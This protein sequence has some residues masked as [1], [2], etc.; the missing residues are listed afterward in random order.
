MPW[1]GSTL[2]AGNLLARLELLL[3]G[4]D[5]PPVVV[6]DEHVAR[7]YLETL[8]EQIDFPPTDAAL[9]LDG[10]TP[11]VNPAQAGP[12]SGR[13]GDSGGAVTGRD[14]AGPRRGRPGRPRGPA[15]R[16]RCRAGPRRGR[17]AV[18]W[19][20]HARPRRSPSRAIP[21]RG[22]SRR[23]NWSTMLVVQ[24]EGGELH[25]ALDEERA[26]G[27]SGGDWPPRWQSSRWTPASTLTMR[28]GSWSPSAPACEG[29]ALDVE[30]SLV[31]IVQELA[32]DNRY[33]PLVVQAVPPRYPDTATAE[34]LGI[35]ELVAEGDSYFIGSPS[36]RDHNIR[37]ATTKF[38]GS[39]SRRARPSPS[40]TTWGR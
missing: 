8:A 13:G 25:A 11:V 29:R 22:C 38:D 7:L 16:R 40:T 23:S 26:A 32:A 31:R 24:A 12:L 15:R 4:L 14:P 3:L 1:G 19:P 6:Y 30:A 27:L 10:V 37:L 34:E 2:W 18:G 5:L 9:S 28:R 35:V 33:V 17:G 36:G 39:S 20:A 21:A